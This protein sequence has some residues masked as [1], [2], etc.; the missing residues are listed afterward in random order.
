MAGPNGAERRGRYRMRLLGSWRLDLGEESISLPLSA[1]RVVAFLALNGRV[2]RSHVAGT[3]WPEVEEN[4][5]HASLRSTVWRITRPCPGLLDTAE[6]QLALTPAVTVDVHGLRR[7]FEA[8]VDRPG[9]RV[10]LEAWWPALSGDLL[11]GWYD[12]WVLVDRERLRQVR[13]HA[14]ESMAHGLSEQRRYAEAIEVGMAA[15]AAAP[16]R[17]SAHREVIRIHLAEGN[18]AEALR[19]FEVCAQL[20]R[21]DLGL[22]PSEKMIDLMDPVIGLADASARELER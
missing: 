10:D 1:Q 5:A 19:Q 11:P 22:Q 17:E 13:V 8:M 18:V 14:L 7:V 9:D 12:D 2:S 4:R 21:D 20:L 16:L 3:L 6:G 15:I